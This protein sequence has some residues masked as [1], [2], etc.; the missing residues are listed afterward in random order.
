M[1]LYAISCV[2]IISYNA[3]YHKN[4]DKSSENVNIK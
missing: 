1:T 2:Y 4:A 3:L